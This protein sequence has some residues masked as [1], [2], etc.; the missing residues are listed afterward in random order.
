MALLYALLSLTYL[1]S[2]LG[3]KFV[4]FPMLGRSHYLVH[5]KLAKELESRGHKVRKCYLSLNQLPEDVFLL[6][7][8]SILPSV[9]GCSIVTKRN[10]IQ[11]F[12]D[13]HDA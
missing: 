8:S 12:A 11:N 2:C 1:S 9:L 7:S 13:Y 6:I 4:A 3:A 10:Y 5:S